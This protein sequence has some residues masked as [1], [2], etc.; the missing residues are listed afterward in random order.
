MSTRPSKFRNAILKTIVLVGMGLPIGSL[1]LGN[2]AMAQQVAG[3][4][5]PRHHQKMR[6][7]QPPTPS[8]GLS[9]MES[10]N[11]LYRYASQPVINGGATPESYLG[12]GFAPVGT[13]KSGQTIN[14]VDNFGR[15]V[16]TYTIGSVND[17]TSFDPQ[18]INTVTVIEY[19]YDLAMAPVVTRVIIGNG[20]ASTGGSNGLGSES[21][22]LV[23]RGAEGTNVFFNNQ[24]LA[25][26]PI[27]F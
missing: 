16:G 19:D 11:F 8:Q 26:K 10:Y 18:K 27:H 17:K 3:N 5:A 21:G 6:V 12:S 9:S 22:S 1:L 20:L 2:A 24:Q 23:G 25:I 14:I 4:T 13:Y 7:Q 15:T